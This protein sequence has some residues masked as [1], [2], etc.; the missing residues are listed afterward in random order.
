MNIKLNVSEALEQSV[1]PLVKKMA[2]E[3]IEDEIHVM[4]NRLDIRLQQLAVDAAKNIAV[5]VRRLPDRR[6]EEV[7]IIVTLQTARGV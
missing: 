6:G 3:I 4:K 2:E 1:I 7:D 5:I